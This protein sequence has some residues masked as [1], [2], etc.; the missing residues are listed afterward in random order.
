MAKDRIIRLDSKGTT[1]IMKV[2]PT[3]HLENLYYG[4]KLRDNALTESLQQKRGIGVGT[5]VGY[6][7]QSPMMFLE[8]ACLETSTPGKG[9]FRSPAVLVGRVCS[10]SNIIRRASIDFVIGLPFLKS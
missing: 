6:T 9:D 7:E 4:R 5:G 1:Y 3:G 2:A 10:L 8:T